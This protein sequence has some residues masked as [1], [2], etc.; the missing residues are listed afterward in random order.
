MDGSREPAHSLN[1][2]RCL[3]S[4]TIS[5]PPAKIGSRT[6]PRPISS[7]RTTGRPEAYTITAPTRSSRSEGKAKSHRLRAISKNIPDTAPLATR[8]N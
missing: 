6:L 7:E 1:L 5:A 8:H 2:I 4:S 3:S